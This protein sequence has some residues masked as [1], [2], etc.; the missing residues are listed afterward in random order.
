MSK[1][2]KGPKEGAAARL[3]EIYSKI[4]KRPISP[5]QR[6]DLEEVFKKRDQSTDTEKSKKIAK[7]ESDAELI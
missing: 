5:E 4:I 7:S 1:I 6:K 2:L 3:R